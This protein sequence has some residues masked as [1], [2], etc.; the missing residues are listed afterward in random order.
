MHEGPIFIKGV[1]IANILNSRAC[2]QIMIVRC[3]VL[4]V[5][6]WTVVS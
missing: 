2:S 5:S 4:V 3:P 6:T 1:I